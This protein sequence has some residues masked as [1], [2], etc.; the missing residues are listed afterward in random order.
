M[1]ATPVHAATEQWSM[2]EA[3]RAFERAPVAR[4]DDLVGRWDGEMA[5]RASLRRLTLAMNAL[6]PLR[7]WCGKEFEGSGMVRN[8]VR[9]DGGVQQ[10]VSAAAGDGVSLVDGRPAVVVDYSGA[11]PPVRWVRGELRWLTPGSEVLGVLLFPVSG[12]FV[13]PLPFTMVRCR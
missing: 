9:R 3:R 13:G 8:L 10:S 1:V 4:F 12:R 11:R 7:G 5:G 6:T 2:R